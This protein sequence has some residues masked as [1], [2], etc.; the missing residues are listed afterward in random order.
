MTDSAAEQQGLVFDERHSS[1]DCGM[2]KDRPPSLLD[3]SQ[4]QCLSSTSLSQSYDCSTSGREWSIS[5]V[6][7]QPQLQTSTSA[8]ANFAVELSTF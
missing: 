3:R 2:K 4:S 1:L 7:S 5:A 6:D 8:P